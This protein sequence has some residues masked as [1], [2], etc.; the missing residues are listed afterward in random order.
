MIQ[1]LVAIAAVVVVAAAGLFIYAATRPDTFRVARSTTVK[2]P[3]EKISA[4]IGDFRSWPAWSPYEKMDPAMART[5]SGPASGKGA[6][7]EW[8]GNSQVGKG[9]M[10]I[11]ELAPTSRIAIKLDFMKP[12]EAH[13]MAEF[14]LEPAGGATKVTWAMQGPSAFMAKVMGIFV[15][16]DKMIGKDFETGLA[17]LKAAAEG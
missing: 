16:L 9:R 4:L 17:N 8:E 15:D 3:P 1:T 12:F 14:L 10:E 2:A 5:L 11:V 6:V 13:N 7:Y